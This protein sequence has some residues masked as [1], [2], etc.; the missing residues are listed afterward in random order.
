MLASL[1]PDHVRTQ[2]LRHAIDV[3]DH[4]RPYPY[5]CGS[6]HRNVFP[7]CGYKASLTSISAC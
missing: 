7:D 2:P 6:I 1:E 5:N 3:V 4:R